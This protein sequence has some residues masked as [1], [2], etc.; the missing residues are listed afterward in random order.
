[1]YVQPTIEQDLIFGERSR[2]Q[3]TNRSTKSLQK[4]CH[5]SSKASA[6]AATSHQLRHHTQH[7]FNQAAYP[8]YHT[9]NTITSSESE[10]I[11]LDTFRSLD[12]PQKQRAPIARLWRSQEYLTSC[13]TKHHTR[14]RRDCACVPSITEHSSIL[15]GQSHRQN[16]HSSSHD[17]AKA[18]P[19]SGRA[20]AKAATSDMLSSLLKSDPKTSIETTS[21]HPSST[22]HQLNHQSALRL[23][24]AFSTAH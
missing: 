3:N 21:K 7:A 17:N 2:N 9:S 1:M 8:I 11:I 22:S 15:G 4:H 18:T 20:S 12:T 6:I 5:H 19:S 14:G 23:L 24:C 13:K 16:Y 10:H